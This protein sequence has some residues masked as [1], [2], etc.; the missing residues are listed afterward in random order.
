[1]SR[2]H[3]F[4]SHNLYKCSMNSWTIEQVDGGCRSFIYIWAWAK[5]KGIGIPLTVNVELS[6]DYY[7]C[8]FLRMVHKW[9]MI[10]YWMRMQM[11]QEN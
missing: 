11:L 10:V 9:N 2:R 4:V 7:L 6:L 8:K 5:D 3:E 1:M